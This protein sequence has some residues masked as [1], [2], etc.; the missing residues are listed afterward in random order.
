MDIHALYQTASQNPLIVAAVSFGGGI[1]AA[2]YALIIQKI[3]KSKW[4][5]AAIR[6]D[7]KLAKAI[8]AELQKDVDEV[9]DAAPDPVPAAAGPVPHS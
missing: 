3:V 8:V 4:V 5:T 9:A 7:P 6:K 1:A 2:N